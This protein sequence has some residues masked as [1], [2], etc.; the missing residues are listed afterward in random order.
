MKKVVYVFFLFV[1]VAFAQDLK[2]DT[3]A[4][5]NAEFIIDAVHTRDGV[6]YELSAT[7]EAGPYGRVYLSYVFTNH[8]DSME[9]GEFTGF[10][11]T[12]MEEEIIKGTTQGVYRKQG[13]VFKM[14]A[15]D[16]LTN[17]KT[18]IVSGVADF[19]NKTLKFKA[20]E[21]KE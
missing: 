19:V 6:N 13:K 7:G 8:N 5:I 2:W 21:V 9:S 11:W 20:S 3:S 16:N 18:Y 1:S 14:Y 12:Q 10:I 4:L 15:L 17:E